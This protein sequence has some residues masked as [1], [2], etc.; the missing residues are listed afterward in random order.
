[1][2]K[3]FSETQE[4]QRVKSIIIDTCVSIAYLT[5]SRTEYHRRC[6]NKSDAKKREYISDQV[7]DQIDV[8]FRTLDRCIA[9]YSFGDTDTRRAAKI[10]IYDVLD[11]VIDNKI[12]RRDTLE[13]IQDNIDCSLV[14]DD[15]LHMKTCSSKIYEYE[16][17]NSM[18][19]V[20]E[21][22]AN[23]QL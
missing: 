3:K 17:R 13:Y 8:A 12:D 21:M 15:L 7:E 16:G 22:I 19:V 23:D 20:L 14:L 11:K 9:N 2:K 1:M 10:A 18:F 4:F 5:Y 6:K